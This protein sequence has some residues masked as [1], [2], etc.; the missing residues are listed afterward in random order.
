V[1][2]IAWV[3][4]QYWGFLG[5]YV[6]A[7]AGIVIERRRFVVDVVA[8]GGATVLAPTQGAFSAGVDFGFAAF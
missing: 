2:P 8:G 5:P 4:G 3:E 1:G 7:K 6:G